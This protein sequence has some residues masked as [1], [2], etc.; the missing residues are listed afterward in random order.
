M[1]SLLTS[2]FICLYLSSGLVGADDSAA[3]PF[4]CVEKCIAK[5]DYAEEDACKR[6]CRLAELADIA[7]GEKRKESCE[8]SCSDNYPIANLSNACK[9]GCGEY[10]ADDSENYGIRLPFGM[11][12]PPRFCARR[13]FSAFSRFFHN[14]PDTPIGHPEHHFDEQPSE[15]KSMSAITKTDA[16]EKH[17][18]SVIVIRP[19]QSGHSLF[20][21]GEVG[22]RGPMSA[23][24][25][26]GTYA[27]TVD[28]KMALSFRRLTAHPVGALLILTFVGLLILLVIQITFRVCRRRHAEV[29]EYDRLPTYVEATEIK[30]PYEDGPNG[31]EKKESLKKDPSA[32]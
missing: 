20:A 2:L 6:G 32:A 8:G 11:R 30:I 25:S 13:M 17:G 14:S 18:P 5:Y 23:R 16:E 12:F 3:T 15:S 7:D 21:D 28:E 4:G 31:D 10:K 19:F 27:L 1:R 9:Y 29:F 22:E 26:D 24:Q